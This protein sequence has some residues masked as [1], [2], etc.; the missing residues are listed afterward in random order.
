MREI[1][2][3]EPGIVGFGLMNK[4]V[5]IEV[6]ADPF[7]LAPKMVEL[8]FSVKDPEKI[9]IISDSV[10]NTKTEVISDGIM[11]GE[12]RLMGGSMTVTESAERLIRAGIDK[13][14]VMKAISENPERYLIV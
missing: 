14:I 11:N 3:R 5:Y 8:I 12:G 2:H 1:H 4:D 9:I 6:I 13:D 10:K 7:H